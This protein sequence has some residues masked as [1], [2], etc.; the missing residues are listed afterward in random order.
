M[1]VINNLIGSVGP[2]IMSAADT[3]NEALT[4]IFNTVAFSGSW[5]VFTKFNWLGALLQFVISA[6]CL[7]GLVL[8]MIQRLVTML[9]LSSEPTFD[10]IHEIKNA[11][12]G[13]K[14]LGLPGLVKDTIGTANHG[15][16]LDAILSF[17]LS[18]LP[19]VKAYSDYAEDHRQYN[20]KDD[21]TITVYML[22]VALPTI[23]IVFFFSIG[24]NGTLGRAYG[25]V[26]SAM[27]NRDIKEVVAEINHR[28]TTEGAEIIDSRNLA[29]SKSLVL[30]SYISIRLKYYNK[31]RLDFS[32]YPGMR[33][34]VR[35]LINFTKQRTVNM[36]T[37]RSLNKLIELLVIIEDDY[38]QYRR[39]LAYRFIRL[40]I[41]LVLY[42]NFVN[43]AV[44]AD[45]ILN[46]LITKE[47]YR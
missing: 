10:R 35:V 29:A 19:D 44:V 4:G 15:T 28:V 42:G 12:R 17:L 43:A 27:A 6:F 2:V 33:S 1:H 9:Y 22:K 46:Q 23:M 32:K 37:M 24:F 20:L 21:D 47:D 34:A 3:G 40:F 39:G 11:G 25:Q 13:G 8:V 31:K 45:F 30:L 14:A 36:Q 5:E 38:V 16:G 41:V 7:I 26:A 18:L